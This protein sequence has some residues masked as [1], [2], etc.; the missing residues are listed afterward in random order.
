[1][2]EWLTIPQAC[3]RFEVTRRTITRWRRHYP[4]RAAKLSGR[5][6]LNEKDLCAAHAEA[7]ERDNRYKVS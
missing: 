7:Y 5:L 6:W 3:E 1:M 2:R 4:I